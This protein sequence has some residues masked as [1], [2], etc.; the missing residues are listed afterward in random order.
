M[1][2]DPD[3]NPDVDRRTR[4][5]ASWVM[6]HPFLVALGAVAVAL[7]TVVQVGLLGYAYQRLG[8]DSTWLLVVL[9][10]SFLGAAVNVPVGRL[11]RP[12][13]PAVRVP[14]AAGMIALV[15]WPIRPAWTRVSVNV[16]GAIVPSALAAYLIVH[17][18]LGWD[19]L[20]AVAVVTLVVHVFAQPV[21]GQGIVVPALVPPATAAI[22]AL[23][24]G[25]PAVPA[26][27]YVSGVLG[28]L[29]GA[30]LLNLRRIAE[31][32]TSAVSIGGAGTFDGVFLSGVMAVL[33]ASL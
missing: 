2:I 16:G 22:T 4:W 9:A 32:D 26:L 10:A 31:L 29:F 17:L 12:G 28:C 27:A 3:R 30:D 21:R 23:L 33:I 14:T 7:L 11:R 5:L 13:P 8:V 18:G 20:I 6:E 24:L 1:G 25:G 15:P 19:A